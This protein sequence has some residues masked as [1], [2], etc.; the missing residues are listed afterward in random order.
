M[1]EVGA[2]GRKGAPETTLLSSSHGSSLFVLV[3]IAKPLG[4]RQ[5]SYKNGNKIK[6]DMFLY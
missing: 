5:I 3:H 4:R 2:Q 1:K 6:I